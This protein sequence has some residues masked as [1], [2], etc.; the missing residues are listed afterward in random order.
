MNKEKVKELI[1][2]DDTPATILNAMMLS[3]FGAAWYIWELETVQSGLKVYAEVEDYSDFVEDKLGALIVLLTNDRF[4]NEWEVFE[5][6]GHAFNHNIVFPGQLQP[7]NVEELNWVL[8]E[9]KLIDDEYQSF[10]SDVNAYI[11]TV[12]HEEGTVG[13]VE[14]IYSISKIKVFSKNI[15]D[16]EVQ[17]VKIQRVK[18]YKLLKIQKLNEYSLKYFNKDLSAHI[19]Y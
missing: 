11:K 2:D 1:L 14:D 10:S 15:L 5:N 19:E 4:Y 3:L 6:I 9:S 8:Y 17:S 13:E 7:M 12:L 16:K 18:S